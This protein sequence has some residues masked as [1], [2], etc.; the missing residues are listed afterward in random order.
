MASELILPAK[1]LIVRLECDCGGIMQRVNA[2]WTDPPKF[3][4]RCPECEA[5]EDRG[6]NYPH[7]RH[8]VDEG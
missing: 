4:Y 6:E 8:V 7:V 5:T 2:V 1:S 3:T